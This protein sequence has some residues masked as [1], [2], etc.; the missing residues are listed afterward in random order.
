MSWEWVPRGPSVRGPPGPILLLP[1]CLPPAGAARPH[2]LPLRGS[3]DDWEGV[4][5][6][7][8]QV[9]GS[10]KQRV[11]GLENHQEQ[12]EVWQMAQAIEGVLHDSGPFTQGGT[13]KTR[14][15]SMKHCAFLL[16]Y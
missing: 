13:P 11:G 7:G 4:L 12:E 1:L 10:Q 9:L 15:L 16:T 3:R 6:T 14:N 2:C 8:G 5:R